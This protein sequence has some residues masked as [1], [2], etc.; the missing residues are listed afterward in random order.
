MKAPQPEE[1]RAEIA[2]HELLIYQVAALAGRHPS[3]VS[4]WLHAKAPMPPAE[5]ARIGEAIRSLSEG[6]GVR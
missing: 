3:T 6:R 1:L 4:R 2:R 5:A